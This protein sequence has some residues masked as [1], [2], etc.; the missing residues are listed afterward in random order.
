MRQPKGSKPFVANANEFL[1]FCL[2]V[3]TS[4]IAGSVRLEITD[5]VLAW[6]LDNAVTLRL[7]YFHNEQ[8]QGDAKMIAYEVSKIFGDGS[9]ES[10]D[11]GDDYGASEAEVW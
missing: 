11:G 1:W 8:R 5:P 3:E 2:T 7:L 6:D 10:S 9:G 4:G